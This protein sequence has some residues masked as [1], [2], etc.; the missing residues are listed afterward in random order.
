MQLPK[1]VFSAIKTTGCLFAYGCFWLAI[2]AIELVQQTI[3]ASILTTTKSESE[4]VID[5]KNKSIVVVMILI[6]P[7][8]R[9]K[10]FANQLNKIN[11]KVKRYLWETTLKEYSALTLESKT[12]F[13]TRDLE[14]KINEAEWGFNFWIESGFPTMMNLI[15]M[16]YLC[17]YTFYLSGLIQL[18]IMLTIGVTTLYFGIKKDLDTKMADTWEK[19]R[20]EREK[21]SQQFKLELPRF[22]YGARS[23]VEIMQLADKHID[24][25]SRFAKIRNEQKILSSLMTEICV[26]IILLMPFS[27]VTGILAVTL[28]FT[29]TVNNL[30]STLNANTHLEG[31]YLAMRKEFNNAKKKVGKNKRAKYYKRITVKSCVI[32]KGDFKLRLA[33]SFKHFIGDVIGFFGPSGEGKSTAIKAMFVG[34]DDAKVSL[35]TKK[36]PKNYFHEVSWFYQNSKQDLHVNKLTLSE[37]FDHSRDENMINKCLSIAKVGNPIK[38]LKKKGRQSD[39][40]WIDI[41]LSEIGEMS[42]GEMTRLAIAIQLFEVITRGKKILIMDEPEQ[43]TDPPIAYQMINNIVNE[44]RD[45]CVIILISHLE[46]YAV[47]DGGNIDWTKRFYVNNGIIHSMGK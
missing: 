46:R 47:G 6:V 33:T 23:I 13:T 19:N 17:F 1:V 32:K 14:R 36:N 45:K 28:K 40:S 29:S 16:S 26:V 2:T 25:T 24:I 42:G 8:L 7:V 43:G 15:S 27:N 9:Y 37:I 4:T 10:V 18:L 11:D 41:E 22:A 34:D 39:K 21:L 38:R 35:S 12:I 30:F 20:K 44:F 3:M 31:Q 5:T